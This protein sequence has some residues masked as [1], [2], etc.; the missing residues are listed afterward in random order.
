MRLV[1]HARALIV[2]HAA[3]LV[4][5]AA[6]LPDGDGDG[7]LLA[8][9]VA[10]AVAAVLA[11]L[12]PARATLAWLIL[13]TAWC[14]AR[15]A[16]VALVGSPTLTGPGTELRAAAGWLLWVPA[17]TIVAAVSSTEALTRRGGGVWDG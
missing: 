14:V 15:A 1:A 13:A 8:L 3:W 10:V 5:T 2:I 17:L 12:W 16:L 9:A 4:W 11:A 7:L 6:V